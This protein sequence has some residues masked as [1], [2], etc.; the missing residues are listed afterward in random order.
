[1]THL[2]VALDG[3]HVTFATVLASGDVYT[4]T[5]TVTDD[6]GVARK[7]DKDDVER[8]LPEFEGLVEARE[9]PAT[10]TVSFLDLESGKTL[11]E[12]QAAKAFED[13]L[14]KAPE[15]VEEAEE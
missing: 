6:D 4:E 5:W 14:P 9:A 2:P 11:T 12:T 7:A 1:M 8:L 15:P 3:P 13:A 10:T